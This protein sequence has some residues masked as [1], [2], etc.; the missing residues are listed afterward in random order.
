MPVTTWRQFFEL[1]VGR[2]I[3]T[4]ADIELIASM[5]DV[6]EEDLDNERDEFIRESQWEYRISPTARAFQLLEGLDLGDLRRQPG[7]TARR[8]PLEFVK[9]GFHPGD[10]SRVVLA[11]VP[12]TASLLQARLVELG[13]GLRLVPTWY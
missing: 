3:E 1:S 7:K 4:A 10:D 8:K 12:V 13:T 2:P 5:D 6:R 9:G 11:E